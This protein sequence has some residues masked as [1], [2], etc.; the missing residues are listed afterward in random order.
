[1]SG[2]E[3]NGVI[4]TRQHEDGSFTVHGW[5][6]NGSVECPLCGEEA[7]LYEDVEE[8]EVYTGKIT[9]WEPGTAECCGL[10]LIRSW[11][12]DYVIELED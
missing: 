5:R 8:W 11:D 7:A 2:E 9:C 10:A 4:T 6:V 3:G 12:R 1:M